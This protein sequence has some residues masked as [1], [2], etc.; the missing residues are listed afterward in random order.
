[1]RTI[2]FGIILLFGFNILAQENQTL[3]QLGKRNVSPQEFEQMY[4]KNLDLIQDP[5]QKDIDNY[6]DLFI[7]YKLELADAYAKKY[8]RDPKLQRELQMYRRDLAKK[9]LSDDEI[10]NHLVKEAYNRMKTDVHV[11][12]IL[13]RVA[14]GASPADTLKA[15]QKIEAIYKKAKSG[16]DFGQLA[17]KY[18][19]DPSVKYNKGDLDYINVF[20]TVYPFETA[21]YQTPVGQISKPFRTRF[22]YHIVKVL[23][24][25]PA[26]GEVEVAHIMTTD[27]RKNTNEADA[28]TRIYQI[29][30]QLKQNKAKFEDLAR[31]FSDDKSSARNGGRL[32]RFGIRQMIPAFEQQAFSLKHPGD[33]SQPFKTQYGWHIIKL[34]K[35]Y[36]VL[37]FEQ[38]QNLV[39][40]KV[41]RDER[42]KM[43]RQKLLQKLN[44]ELPIKVTGKLQTIA[45]HINRNF[46]ENKWKIPQTPEDKKSLFIIN[47][48]ETVTYHDFYQYLYK[49]QRHNPQLIKQKEQIISEA[50]KNFKNDKLLDYY[51]RHLEQFYPE[52]AHIMNEYKHGLMLYA[53][54]KE[55]I[56]DKAEKDTTG[57]KSFYK[58][59]KNKYR[60]P[61]RFVILLV[62][63]PQRKMAKKMA[64]D[65]RKGLSK[66]DLIKKYGQYGILTKEKEYTQQ[67]MP[68]KLDK[69]HKTVLQKENNQYAIY[70]L[71][72]IKP[73]AVPSLKDI[74]GQV[75]A[76]Y[77]NY[78]E[79]QWLEQL[80]KKYPVKIN[81]KVWQQMRAKYKK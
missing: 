75:L 23:D 54:K 38:V 65:L 24:K 42:S 16:T 78:L 64:K 63:T 49:R 51:N 11:A 20:N 37:P 50:F 44:K 74:K 81:E 47:N 58:K 32:H 13:V 3:M 15:Y 40:Q 35:K 72:Q 52:F 80:R 4:V 60:L 27:N 7:K 34:L 18:S 61:K 12:H 79:K 1:M 21:A 57:L 2:L 14:P 69:Q 53:I 77:Q 33:I 55:Q 17:L 29:Y 68:V 26:R 36:P 43:G 66:N 56:W 76:D 9:Y 45:K 30:E 22:G 28:K 62:Q 71:V 59:N 70:H 19:E 8:D 31:K 10:I 25:R 41:L 39:R 73:D 67:N 5:A 46:F 6:L 48:D